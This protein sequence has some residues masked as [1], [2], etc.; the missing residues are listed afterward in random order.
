MK[1]TVINRREFLRNI[2]MLGA[3]VL[4]SASPWL[5]VFQKLRKLPMKNAVWLLSGRDR[6][7]VS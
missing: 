2:G 4:L 3:G 7:D 6:E 5:S 1:D